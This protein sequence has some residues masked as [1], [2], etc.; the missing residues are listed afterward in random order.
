LALTVRPFVVMTSFIMGSE[1]TPPL[2]TPQCDPS[3]TTADFARGGSTTKVA[4][5][6]AVSGSPCAGG[7]T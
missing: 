1:V 7:L 5:G 4:D 2:A 6:R 3:C